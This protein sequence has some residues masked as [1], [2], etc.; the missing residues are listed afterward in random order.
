METTNKITIEIDKDLDLLTALVNDKRNNDSLESIDYDNIIFF[1]EHDTKKLIMI[2]VYDFS[3]FKKKM[4]SKFLRVE[5]NESINTW[6]YFLVNSFQA[7]QQ[8]QFNTN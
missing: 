3:I 1:V 6:L 4:L 7:A 2:Q 8:N 5:S